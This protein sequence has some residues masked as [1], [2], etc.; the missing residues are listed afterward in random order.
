MQSLNKAVLYSIFSLRAQ[1]GWNPESGEISFTLTPA[2][3]WREKEN[4][5]PFS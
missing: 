5:P 2:F 3:S 4:L 1:Q